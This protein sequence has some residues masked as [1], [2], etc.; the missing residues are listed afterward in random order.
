MVD[1]SAGGMVGAAAGVDAAVAQLTK[2]TSRG[3]VTT[4]GNKPFLAG[5]VDTV[6]HVTE[7]ELGFITHTNQARAGEKI[8]IYRYSDFS[9][10]DV[11]LC[12]LGVGVRRMDV[13]ED[14]VLDIA[15]PYGVAV[16]VGLQNLLGN[17]LVLLVKR[18]KL[19]ICPVTPI[20]DV[21]ADFSVKVGSQPFH[22]FCQVLHIVGGNHANGFGARVGVSIQQ[23]NGSCYGGVAS[24]AICIA[25]VCIVHGGGAVY[26]DTDEEIS[27]GEPIQPLWGEQGAVGGDA[28]PRGHNEPVFV[29]LQ[30]LVTPL[31]QVPL[32]QRL[33]TKE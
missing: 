31:Q 2:F 20:V 27:L 15:E 10:S 5:T 18:V 23:F 16:A 30:I 25:T 4:G 33:A 17:E 9:F 14:F 1:V 19:S 32:Q 28:V 8:A 13:G 29:S 6:L 3:N 26:G 7:V 21:E 22:P 12:A 11:A 24:A